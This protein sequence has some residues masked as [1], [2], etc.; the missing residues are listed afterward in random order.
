MA[1]CS[2][3]AIVFLTVVSPTLGRKQRQKTSPPQAEPFIL[4]FFTVVSAVAWKTMHSWGGE[5]MRADGILRNVLLK[6]SNAAPT[7]LLKL[8]PRLVLSVK[9]NCAPGAIVSLPSKLSMFMLVHEVVSGREVYAPLRVG[10][11]LDEVF[12]VLCGGVARRDAQFLG[13]SHGFPHG[14]AGAAEKRE[15]REARSAH[16]QELPPAQA[17]AQASAAFQH[18]CCFHV[19]PASVAG[20]P[21]FGGPWLCVPASRRVC[22]YRLVDDVISAKEG[23]FSLAPENYAPG[24]ACA[25]VAGLV[26]FGRHGT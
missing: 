25:G 21:R 16:F 1:K 5:L 9:T 10:E 13:G 18:P 23:N 3:S 4:A 2:P 24:G 15:A 17:F 19:P 12:T 11:R 20:L 26:E 7:P 14:G 8:N 6:P 22:P